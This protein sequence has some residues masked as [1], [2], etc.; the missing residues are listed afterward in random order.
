MI[1]IFFLEHMHRD[2]R[3]RSGDDS[4]LVFSENI[5]VEQ[6]VQVCDVTVRVDRCLT[7]SHATII[8]RQENYTSNTRL[9]YS[10]ALHQYHLTHEKLH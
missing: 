9:D 3:R 2:T 5:E 6:G 1:S 7:S 4:R 8:C 10:T